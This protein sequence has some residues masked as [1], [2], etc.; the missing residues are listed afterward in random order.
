MRQPTV[1][2]FP[3]PGVAIS[4]MAGGIKKPSILAKFEGFL[5]SYLKKHLVFSIFLG[6]KIGFCRHFVAICSQ[7]V[8][9]PITLIGELQ[10]PFR[11]NAGRVFLFQK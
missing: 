1:G 9:K 4:N 8:A 6:Q 7:N 11:H 2:R 5:F 10:K 3:K